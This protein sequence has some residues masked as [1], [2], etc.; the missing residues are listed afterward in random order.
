MSNCCEVKYPVAIALKDFNFEAFDEFAKAGKETDYKMDKDPDVEFLKNA[1]NAAWWF[2][3]DVYQIE[4]HDG[5]DFVVF[6][7]GQGRS[8]HCFRDLRFTPNLIGH[9]RKIR[10]IAEVITMDREN[11]EFGFSPDH[12]DMV[13]G[14]FPQLNKKEQ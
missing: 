8:T 2:L 6:N 7:L 4:N 14:I 10:G 9:F 13:P 5:T 1:S 11:P 12:Y 3:Q